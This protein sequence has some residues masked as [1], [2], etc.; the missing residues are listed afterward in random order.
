MKLKYSWSVWVY[1]DGIFHLAAG[2]VFGPHLDDFAADKLRLSF[3]PGIST[4][5]IDENKLFGV[6]LG[7]GTDT[8]E[9][10]LGIAS[11]RLAV[12]ISYGF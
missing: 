7:F 8:F 4:S 1:L 12:G 3:G 5:A 2:N 6:S 9:Q 10:G 11:V